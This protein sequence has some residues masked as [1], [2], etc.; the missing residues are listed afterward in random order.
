MILILIVNN[1]NCRKPPEKVTFILNKIQE[2]AKEGKNLET[3][4]T[5]LCLKPEINGSLGH[6]TSGAVWKCNLYFE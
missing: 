4:A 2:H 5:N 1:C 6:G 3:N